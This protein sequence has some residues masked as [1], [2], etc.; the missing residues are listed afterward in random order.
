MR[1][2]IPFFTLDEVKLKVLKILVSDHFSKYAST[3][4]LTDKIIADKFNISERYLFTPCEYTPLQKFTKK[5]MNHV[6]RELKFLGYLTKY[7]NRFW[8]IDK[9]KI[10]KDKRLEVE[11][12]G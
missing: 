11:E 2:I 10:K 3:R 4:Q 1:P 9:E 7:S 5:Q 12:V 8:L 6:I